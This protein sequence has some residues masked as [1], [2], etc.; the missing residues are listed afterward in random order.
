[1]D[2]GGLHWAEA[3]FM[4]LARAWVTAYVQTT[5]YTKGFTF[6]QNVNIAFNRYHECPIRRSS[7]LTKS[8]WYSLNAQYVAY[9]GI[10][11]QE[12]FRNSSG[13][14]EEDRE[15]NAH[16]I[17]QGLNGGNKFKHREAYKILA[18]EP[19]CANLRDDGLNYAGNIPRNVARRISDNSS[20]GNSVRSNNLSEDPGGPPIPQSAGPNFDLDGS[21]HEGGSRPIG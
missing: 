11:T 15:N 21:L 9:K 2:D 5:G 13:K 4:C 20:P 7:G 19:R 8:Q 6:Y 3:N 1:M 16:K 18:Q 12:R 14:I 17:Y 10:V